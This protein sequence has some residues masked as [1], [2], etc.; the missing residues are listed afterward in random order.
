MKNIKK[1]EAEITRVLMQNGAAHVHALPM[2]IQ[3]QFKK[4]YL[5]YDSELFNQAVEVL[6]EEK[7]IIVTEYDKYKF[8]QRK[9]QK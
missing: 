2:I 9:V 6:I 5:T 8:I 1:Y 3:L 4:E 7:Q